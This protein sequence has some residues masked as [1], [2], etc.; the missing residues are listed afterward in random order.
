[1]NDYET[2]EISQKASKEVITAAYK[3]LVK[4]YHPDNKN[5]TSDVERFRMVKAAYDRLMLGNAEARYDSTQRQQNKQVDSPDILAY[6]C[7]RY[8]KSFDYN[9]AYEVVNIFTSNYPTDYRCW[10]YLARLQEDNVFALVQN[11]YYAVALALANA[12]GI[13]NILSHE[14]LRQ[15]NRIRVKKCKYCNAKIEED[16]VYCDECGMRQIPYV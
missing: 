4:K 9:S 2:L 16:D 5:G 6:K 8:F 10:L 13:I 14:E 1:M 7:E 3:A 12:D 15:L 11:K